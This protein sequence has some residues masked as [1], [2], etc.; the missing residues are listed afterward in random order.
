M[1]SI[2]EIG[3]SILGDSPKNFYILGGTEYGIKDKYLEI[4][5]SKIG[6]KLEY[7]A[8]SD[9]VN[10]MSSYHI[11]PLQ[12][13]VYV[14]RYDKE[15]VANINKDIAET[16]LSLPIIGTLVLIYEG[17]KELN[18]LN[19]FFP[20]N[21]AS[22]DT[23]D[24]KLMAKYLKSDFPDLDDRTITYASRQASNYYQAKSICRCLYLVQDKV[25]LSEQQIVYLFDIKNAYTTNDIQIAIA[26]RS[27]GSLMKIIEHYDGDLQNILYQ[28]LRV[29]IEIDKCH[30]SK[31][32][33]SPLKSYAKKWK[34]EDVYQMFNHTYAAIKE[35]RSGAVIE[36]SDVITYL[37]AL[38]LFQNVPDRRLLI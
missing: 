30:S 7:E 27:F 28:F 6:P 20:N 3:L 11:V 38:M 17:D 14:V 33:N 24:S 32:S 15:F 23:I 9:I 12:P 18:K 8:V 36:V 21:T 19:K 22:I 37:G 13:Q 1:L 34:P 25:L 26:N 2:Q 31:Y 29:M 35:L 4:L 5:V 10:L 16:I